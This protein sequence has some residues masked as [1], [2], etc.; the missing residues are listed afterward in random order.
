MSADQ[1]FAIRNTN[2]LHP[3]VCQKSGVAKHILDADACYEQG[4]FTLFSLPC[5]LPALF[6]VRFTAPAD[7]QTGDKITL[8]GQDFTVKTRTMADPMNMAFSAGAVVQCDVDM[9][10]NLVFIAS[11]KVE[12][13]IPEPEPE[14]PCYY[15]RIEMHVE[16]TGSDTA[17]DGS[18]ALPFRTVAGMFSFL[19]REY[20]GRIFNLI[21]RLGRGH[22]E[23]PRAW[24]F[25]SQPFWI[26]SL[27]IHGK[28]Y[29]DRS[30]ESTIIGNNG[31]AFQNYA[32]FASLHNVSVNCDGQSISVV[33]VSVNHCV[34]A[35]TGWCNFVNQGT[36]KIHGVSMTG[37]S[38]TY[39]GVDNGDD[40]IQFTGSF[41]SAIYATSHSAI[42]I[43]AKTVFQGTSQYVIFMN[44]ASY[45]YLYAPHVPTFVGSFRGDVRA[46]NGST[47]AIGNTNPASWLPSGATFV[48]D[49]TSRITGQ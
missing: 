34:V 2:E 43:A 40:N 19:E 10:R 16:Q 46:W 1:N 22:F 12:I 39:I 29:E 20:T 3:R 47:I 9:E 44:G 11:D 17:G 38:F 18:Q 30:L 5:K 31:I 42:N 7:Y 23:A 48:K 26:Q 15:N 33:Q 37:H 32:Q 41:N 27:E 13:E 45:L 8:K 14:L 6:T 21:V 36:S 4:R 28:N 24:I 35:I 25:P 49:D